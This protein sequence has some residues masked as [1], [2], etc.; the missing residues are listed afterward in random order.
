MFAVAFLFEFGSVL[1]EDRWLRGIVF[2]SL[3]TPVLPVL[4]GGTTGPLSPCVRLLGYRLPCATELPR[5]VF[6]RSQ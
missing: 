4:G 6:T 5:G 2:H 1:R 3:S